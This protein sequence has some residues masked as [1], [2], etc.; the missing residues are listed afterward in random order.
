MLSHI[1]TGRL[2]LQLFYNLVV[3]IQS[4]PFMELSLALQTGGQGIRGNGGIVHERYETPT[5]KAPFPFDSA[6][7]DFHLVR[8]LGA[9][10]DAV[11]V[12]VG[13]PLPLF[14]YR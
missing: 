7:D 4:S 3:S 11:V 5:D 2:H 8:C 9:R 1:K 10:P 14:V 13:L 12:V 6:R